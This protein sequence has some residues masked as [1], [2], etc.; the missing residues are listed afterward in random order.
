MVETVVVTASA[1][2]F[3]GLA[4]AL[5]AI[6]VLVE[7]HPLMN[8]APPTDWGPLDAALDRW[9]SY[10]AVAFT[11]QRAAAA[12]VDRMAGRGRQRLQ[13]QNIPMVWAGGPATEAALGETLGRV[14]TPSQ[15]DAATLGAA[16]ALGRAMVDAGVGGPVLFFCGDSRRDELPG[17]LRGHGIRVDEVECYRSVLASESTAHA[18]A[19]RGTVLVVASP[20]VADLLVRACPPDAR[21]DLLAVGPTTAAS[22]RAAGWSPAAVAS[23]PSVEA[24]ATAVRKVLARRS[25]HE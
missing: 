13:G 22:A 23:E 5:R 19:V 4:E 3:P 12:L 8:F 15:A 21:P 6:P 16:E 10:G 25:A 17:L 2:A 18:A 1:G 9:D 20:T 24:L 11:S 7:E 14:R